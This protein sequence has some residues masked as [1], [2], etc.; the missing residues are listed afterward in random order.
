[1][2]NRYLRGALILIKSSLVAMGKPI[3]GLALGGA[4]LWQVAAHSGP[5]NGTAYV[6][7][8]T[9]E[10]DITIARSHR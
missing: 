7:V 10:A 4:I 3:A 5:S 1:M 6:H 8:A 2:R 9:P